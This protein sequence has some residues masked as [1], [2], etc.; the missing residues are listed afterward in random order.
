MDRSPTDQLDY[1]LIIRN[2]I[3]YCVCVSVC[4]ISMSIQSVCVCLYLWLQW[5]CQFFVGERWRR[6]KK[7]CVI[8]LSCYVW[9]THRRETLVPLMAGCSIFSPF[10][11]SYS[12]DA[13][14]SLHKFLTERRGRLDDDLSL[15]ACL[16][17]LPAS[18]QKNLVPGVILSAEIVKLFAGLTLS[19]LYF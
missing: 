13:C 1:C 2:F 6:G 17:C 4:L 18:E 8:V 16:P 14:F 15:P 10:D 9:Q 5:C 19:A 12:T 3:E 7:N 11:Y